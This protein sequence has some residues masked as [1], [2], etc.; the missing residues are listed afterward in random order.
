MADRPLLTYVGLSVQMIILCVL[1][2]PF[3]G[4][5]FAQPEVTACALNYACSLELQ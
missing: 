4:G 3:I 5:C 1:R 2:R